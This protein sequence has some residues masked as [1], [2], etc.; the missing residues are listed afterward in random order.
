MVLWLLPGSLCLP[1]FLC[2]SAAHSHK[3]ACARASVASRLGKTARPCFTL[4]QLS[5]LPSRSFLGGAGTNMPSPSSGHLPNPLLSGSPFGFLPVLPR[6]LDTFFF[7][8]GT[9][10]PLYALHFSLFW[11]MITTTIMV[12]TNVLLPRKRV[13]IYFVH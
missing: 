13:S 3:P 1:S 8:P 7:F 11:P 5:L 6:L 2:L 10:I 9:Q 12:R 4:S